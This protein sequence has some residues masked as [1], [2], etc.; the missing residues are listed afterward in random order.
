MPT[1][2][3]PKEALSSPASHAGRPATTAGRPR[4]P[5]PREALTLRLTPTAA[6]WYSVYCGL[7]SDHC[8]VRNSRRRCRVA[9]DRRSDEGSRPFAAWRRCGTTP[10]LRKESSRKAR[11]LEPDGAVRR[12]GLCT[13]AARSRSRLTTTAAPLIHHAAGVRSLLAGREEMRVFPTGIRVCIGASAVRSTSRAGGPRPT[14]ASAGAGAFAGA[15]GM[16]HPAPGSRIGPQDPH[17]RSAA[18][19]DVCLAVAVDVAGGR[20]SAG[21]LSSC[22]WMQ[23]A[24]T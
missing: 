1:R 8:P 15:P 4:R 19:D 16:A 6:R 10:A 5:R 7:S 11:I 14:L 23:R 22:V 13:V 20:F 18:D 9:V 21:T 12:D 2:V 24:S 3:V 17:R